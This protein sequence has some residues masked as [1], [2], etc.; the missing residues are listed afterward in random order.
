MTIISLLVLAALLYSLGVILVLIC[1]H[2]MKR[3]YREMRE[4]IDVLE[5]SGMSMALVHVKKYK[6][7]EDYRL[8]IARIQ[9]AQKFIL[10]KAVFKEKYIK[11]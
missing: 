8:K 10:E 2:R 9:K 7:T 4:K 3:L 6:I 11:S 1:E 5:N